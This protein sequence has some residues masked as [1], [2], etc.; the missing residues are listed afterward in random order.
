MS[1]KV[2]APNRINNHFEQK[3]HQN[4]YIPYE[5]NIDFG[6]PDDAFHYIYVDMRPILHQMKIR[7]LFEFPSRC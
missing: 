4:T 1:T 3:H 2:M 6:M 5:F 7:Q